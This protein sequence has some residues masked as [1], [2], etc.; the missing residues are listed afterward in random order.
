MPSRRSAFFDLLTRARS[1]VPVFTIHAE[2]RLLGGALSAREAIVRL[3]GDPQA[4]YQTL[5]WKQGRRSLF[6][7]ESSGP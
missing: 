7:R 4:P 5:S 3:S 1:G 2:A 6:D